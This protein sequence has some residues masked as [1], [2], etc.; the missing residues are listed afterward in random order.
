MEAGV[1]IWAATHSKS[2]PISFCGEFLQCG[3]QKKGVLP[4]IQRFLFGEKWLQV[5]HISRKKLSELTIFR[6]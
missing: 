6:L 3:D 5:G 2:V 1:T 4:F